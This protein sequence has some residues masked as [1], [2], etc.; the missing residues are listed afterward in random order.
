MLALRLE[1]ADEADLGD[2]LLDLVLEHAAVALGLDDPEAVEKDVPFRDQRL[3]S[4][5]GA[6]MCVALAKATGLALPVTAVFDYPTPIVLAEHLEQ[7]AR[8]DAAPESVPTVRATVHDDDPVA[9]VGLACRLPGGVSSPEQLWQLLIDDR[10]VV[11][12]FPA[13]RGWEMSQLA[14]S[15]TS[16]GGFL[17]DAADFDA[18]FFGI[19]PREAQAMDPQQR[20]VLETSWEAIERAGIDPRTLRGSDTGVF[21]GAMAQDYGLRLHEPSDGSDGYR[22]TG[23]TTSVASGRVAYALGL[24]GPA[25]TVDTACSSSL[26]AVHLAADAV[27]RGECGIALAGGVTV[28]SSPGIFVEFSRQGG[29]SPDGR[30]KAFSDDAD[31]TG[32]GE[33]VGLLLLERLSDAQR[34]GHPILAVIR[35]SAVNQDGASN[36]LTAPNGPSQQRVIR[37]ALA[38]AGLKPRDVD[39]VEAHGTGTRLGDP[40][41][42]QALLATYGQDRE[43]PLWLGSIKSNI[44][45][46]QAAAGAAGIIKMILAMHHGTLPRTLHI[47]QP[48]TEVDWN[49]GQLALLTEAQPWPRHDRPRRAAVSSFGISGTNAHVIL[50]QPPAADAPSRVPAP[51]LSDAPWLLS[52]VDERALQDQAGRLARYLH[53]AP[54]VSPDDVGYTLAMSRGGFTTRAA[55][56][57]HSVEERADALSALARGTVHPSV[58]RGAAAASGRVVFVFP[59]Q[60]SQWP[61]MGADLYDT[62]PVFADWIDR[63]EQALAPHVNWSLTDILR[64]D[65]TALD[66]VDV[67]QPAL[68]A[69]MVSL[70]ETWRSLGIHPDAVIGHSQGEIAAATLAGALTLDDAARIVALR[71]QIIAQRLAGQGSMASVALSATALNDHLTNHP[72]ITLA[73][74]NGPHTTVVAG[75]SEPLEHFLTHLEQQDIRV[76]RI[77]VD[78][79]SHT[80]E[81]ETIRTELATALADITPRTTH[82]DFYS[83]VTG[84]RTDGTE[85]T[86]DYWYQNLRQPVQFHPTVN[87]LLNDR[88]TTFLEP[89]AHPVLTASVQDTADV[90]DVEVTVN[91]ALRRHG[92]SRA[93]FFASTASVWVR[94]HH[95]D[96]AAQYPG[97]GLVPLPTYPFQRTRYWTDA[98]THSASSDARS[99]GDR[100]FWK[101]VGDRDADALASLLG[102][103]EEQ[104]GWLSQ[105]LPALSRRHDRHRQSSDLAALSYVV[106]W[107]PSSRTGSGAPTGKWLVIVPDG[108]HDTEWSQ[109]VRAGLGASGAE[110]VELRVGSEDRHTL[111]NRLPRDANAVVSLLPMVDSAARNDEAVPAGTAAT[112]TL[113]HALA[114]AGLDVPLWTLTSGAVA[115]DQTDALRNPEQSQVWG[116]GR[117]AALEQP[118]RWGGLVDLPSSPSERTV[119]SLLSV[120]AQGDEDQVAIRES[121]TFVRRLVHASA[122]RPA[123]EVRRDRGT[124]LITGGTGALGAQ[125]ARRIA[126]EGA[127]H[128]VLASR[129][130]P[131]APGAQSLAAELQAL[132]TRVD[133]VVCDVADRAAV[134]QL[135]EDFTVTSVFHAA[136]I[137]DD[138]VVDLLTVEQLDQVLRVKAVGAR[139]L[140]EL[141]ADLDEFVLFSSIAG[142]LGIPG[143]G[144]YAPGNAYLD[145][146]AEHR[147]SLGL[148]ATSYAWGPWAG[149]GMAALDGVQDRLQRHGVLPL[150]PDLAL[151]LLAQGAGEDGAS[152]MVADIQWDRFH[153]AY[154]EARSRPFIEDLPEVRAHAAAETR[155]KDREPSSAAVSR[156]R[157]L[158]GSARSAAVLEMVRAQVAAVLGHTDVLSLDVQRPLRDLGFDSLTGVDLRNRLAAETGIR[159]P[160]SLIFDYPTASAV[161]HHVEAMLFGESDVDTVAVSSQSSDDDPVVIVAMACRYPGSVGSPE[162]L[163]QLLVDG[164]DAIGDFPTDRGWDLERLL[165]SK[166]PGRSVTGRG[167]FLYDAADFDTGL[168]G[169]SPREAL[170]MDPQQRLL[171]EAAWETFE[172]AGIDPS[173]VRGSQ[174]GVFVG[175]TYQDYQS[176]VA[177]PPAE[178]EGYLLTG[179]TASVASGRIS[180]TFGLEGPAVTIDTACS[181]SLVALHLAVESV[182]RGESSAALAGGV[183]LMATP[184]MFTEF[185]RQQG[186]SSDGTCK[187]FSSDADGFGSAEG[188]GLLLVERLSEA[189]SKGHPVLA[190]VRGSA[191]NQDGASN[192]LTAPNGPSQQRVIRQALANA[193]LKPSDVDAVEAHGTG[194]RLGDPIEAQAL[195]AAYGQD[196]EQPLWLGSIKSNIGH[197]QA[198]AGAAGIIK[199]ILA[200][201]HGTLPRTLHITE[202]TTEVDWS[203]GQLALLTEE[204]SWPEHDRPRRAAVSSFG[205]SGTNAH[206]ILE[207]APALSETERAVPESG[208]IPWVMSA[209]NADGLREQ[210][211]RLSSLTGGTLADVGYSLVKARAALEHRAVVLGAT[212]EAMATGLAAVAQGSPAGNVVEGVASAGNGRVVFVFPGQGSQ[213]PGMGAD[214]YDTSPVFADWIDRC[215]QALAPHV[216]WSLTDVLRNDHTAL[217]RVDVVQPALWAMMVSLA[218]TWRSLGIHPDA[219]IGHSQGEIAAATLAGALTL[220]DAAR[221]VALRSQIIAQ[222]LAGQGSMASVALSATALHDHLTNH[223]HITLA[224]HNGPHT[225]VVAGPSEPLE[226]FLTH[227]EQ[228]DIRVRRITV[229]YASHTPEVETI[230][231]ELATALADITPRTTHIDFYSTV[232]GTRTDGTEL[233]PDYWY[234]N[235][236]QP[237]QFH[238]TVNKLLND[239][240]TTFLE[241]SA[242]PVLTAPLTE[243]SDGITVIGT[244][245]RDSGSLD[246]MLASAA[247]AWVSGLPVDWTG[248]YPGARHTP[249]PTYPFQRTRY[250]MED[251]GTGAADLSA[252]GQTALDHPLLTA[253]VDHPNGLETLFTGRVALDQQPWLSDHAVA[254]VLLLPGTAFLEMAVRAGDEV[255][256]DLVEDLTLSA[257][258]VVPEH[259]GTLLRVQV[260]SLDAGR[261]ALAV[262]ARA[263]NALQGDPWTLHASGTL[264]RSEPAAVPVPQA[265]LP[266]DASPVQVESTYR[267]LARHGYAYGPAFQGLRAL[268]QADGEVFAEIA[269]PV[270]QHVLA[271]RFVLHPALLDAAAQTV[272]FAANPQNGLTSVLPWEWQNFTVHSSGATAARAHLSQVS[273]TEARLLLLDPSGL[274]IAEAGAL[275]LRQVDLA[276]IA[277]LNGGDSVPL[278][279]DWREFTTASVVPADII[280]HV[281][282]QTAADLVALA[283][284]VDAEG[285]EPPSLVFARLDREYPA[286]EEPSAAAAHAAASQT[287]QLLQTWLAEPVFEQ[288]HL[289]FVTS[290]AA[291]V[292]PDDAV[293]TRSATVWGMVR[294]AQTEHPDRFVLADL[295]GSLKSDQVLPITVASGEPQIAIRGGKPLFP[296]LIRL[297]A[298]EPAAAGDD[299]DGTVL[300]T[301]GTGTVG[302]HIARHLVAHHG[303]RRLLLLS[304]KGMEADGAASL[305]ADLRDNGAH[306]EIVACDAADRAK[307]ATI[308]DEL[309][310]TYPVTAVIHAA[311]ALADGALMSLT[312][313]QVTQVLRP[314]IDAAVHL[315]ELARQHQVPRF[316]LVSSAAGVLGSAGQA[317]YAAA[318]AF[319]DA[320]A[321][322]RHGQGER[323]VSLAWGLWAD[324]SA[325]TSTLTETDVRRLSALGIAPM[326]T[327]AALASFDIAWRGNDEPV[328]VPMRVDATALSAM[329][330]PVPPMLRDLVRAPM[331]RAL[332]PSGKDD[333]PMADIPVEQRAEVLLNLVRTRA[334]A[335]LGYDSPERV[336]A[337]RAFRD[338]GFDSLAAVDLRNQLNVATGLRLPATV[339][340][341]HPTPASMSEHLLEA[342]YGQAQMTATV[343]PVASQTDDPVVIVAMSC[344]FPGG[345]SSP[346]A[347]WRLLSDA[348]DAVAAMPSDRGWFPDRMYGSDGAG[349]SAVNTAEGAFLP[350]AADFD[351]DLFG[352]SPREALAMDPQQRLLLETSWEAFERAGIDPRSLRGTAT[353]VFAGVMYHDYG[354][355]LTD[356]PAEVEGYVINGS[357]GSVASGRVAYA[358]GLEGPAI[359]IDTACSSSLVA[360]HLAANAI[361]NGECTMALAGGVTVMSTP[362]PFVE[363]SRQGGLASD[364]RCKAFSDTADGT[365]WGEGV[366]LLLLERLSDAQRNGHS[367][368]AVIRGSAVNQ[369]GASNGLTAPNGPSQQRVIRQALANA[370]LKPRDVDAVEAHGTGTRLG[371][372]IEAQALLATYGQDREQPL[373]LGSIKSN[374]GH[375]Q[376]AAGAAGIIKMILA[377]H[378]GTL[379]RTL[380]ITQPTSQVD[381]AAGHISLLTEEQPWPQH[382]RPRRAGV[383]S[384]GVS[385]TNAHIILEQPPRED[386]PADSVPGLPV[387]PWVLSA[388]D[389]YAL[390]A[391][392]SQLV[393]SL[394]DDA[395]LLDI[396]YTLSTTRASFDER[397]VVWAG[398]LEVQRQAL[399]ALSK[400]TAH[401]TCVSG[402]R[403]GG[404]L[405]LLFSGQG[406]QRLGM[407]RE[408]YDAYS[409][410]ADAFDTVCAELDPHLPRPLRDVIF[411]D[412]ADVLNETQFTQP[413]LFAVHVALYRLWESWGVT[414]DAVV[415]HSIG[416]IAAAYIA[417]VLDLADAATLIIAR[418][419]L[420]QDMP[421]GGAMV[422]IDIAE[423]DILP[424]LHDYVDSVGIAAVNSSRS[425]VLS[426]DRTALTHITDRLEGHRITWLRVSHAFHSPL[427]EPILDEFR[428]A[429][430]GLTF[431]AP[432]IPLISSVTGRSIDHVDA[433]HWIRHARHTVR[434]ADALAHAPA[435]AYLEIGPGATLLP[436]VTGTAIP[437]LDP[438]KAEVQAITSALAKLTVTGIDVDWVTYFAGSGARRIP[439]PT[440]PFQH[441]RYWLDN[442][443]SGAVDLSAAGLDSADHPILKASVTIPSSGRT[444]LTGRIDLSSLPWLADHTVGDNVVFPGTAF[445]DLVLYA[446]QRVNCSRL[447]E[448]TMDVP[449]LL[450]ASEPVQVRVDVDE[451]VSGRHTVGV[452]SRP[453]HADQSE[454]WTKHC[455]GSL[456]TATALPLEAAVQWPPADAV[457]IDI[458]DFYDRMAESGVTYGPAFR[459]MRSVWQHGEELYAEIRMDGNSAGFTVHPALFDAALHVMA[460][461]ADQAHVTLPFAWS[462]VTVHNRASDHLLIRLAHRGPDEVTLDLADAA[463]AHIAS[464]SS[465]VGR[466]IPEAELRPRPVPALRMD[467]QPLVLPTVSDMPAGVDILRITAQHSSSEDVAESAR[468]TAEAAMNSV[469]TW[470][471]Q[472]HSPGARLV[473]ATSG[474]S[475]HDPHQLLPAASVWGLVRSAQVEHPG[476]LVLV[477]GDGPLDAA[478]AS[479]EEQILLHSDQALVPRLIRDTSTANVSP[480]RPGTVLVTGASGALGSRICRH[481]VKAHGFRRLLLVTRRG[482][483][484]SGASELYRQLAQLGAEVDF[485]ACDITDRQ[486]LSEVLS[487][488]PADWPLSAVVH[489]AGVVDDATFEQQSSERLRSVF[490]PKAQGAWN[491]HE[492]TRELDVSAFVLFSSAAGTLG[493]AGQANYAAANAFLDALAESRREQGL[494]ALSLAWG[495]WNVADGMAG[496][497][498]SVDRKRLARSGV[499][500]MEEEQGLALFDIALGSEHA[501]VVPL[502]LDRNAL[503]SVPGPVPCVLRGSAAAPGAKRP[504]EFAASLNERVSSLSGDARRRL[505]VET[506]RAEVAA[507]LGHVSEA[508]VD[509]RRSFSDLGFDSLTAVEL[510]NRLSALT[511]L[512][513]PA[514]VVFDYPST[515]ALADYLDAELPGAV[516]ALS[517]ELDR[518]EDLLSAAGGETDHA[519]IAGRLEY[520][521]A[522]W[523]RLVPTRGDDAGADAAEATTPEELMD[524]IDR[525]L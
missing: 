361:R 397:A 233:T 95:V 268:W 328:L 163:W 262:Y 206:V 481:L 357:A 383:S 474:M 487:A 524:F 440:Y 515:G 238:P 355:R 62:S 109:A 196:R 374:I 458:G 252:A 51:G 400:G 444:L 514:S 333:R 234:Q 7:R 135:L 437:S 360:V 485:A 466:P 455:S 130:G 106:R 102:L 174:T 120:V 321:Q 80:P 320:L 186:L 137:L 296:R 50:E 494:P 520:L 369:D 486:A 424:H 190:V 282:V 476:R 57:G 483:S 389:E 215:E 201:H 290:N 473:V 16:R 89:S 101:A 213:W 52:A 260:S 93:D 512:E 27:R 38:N 248:L 430:T 347:L 509:D 471:A 499:L 393:E 114:D 195:Q 247:Q 510:R 259:G 513:L 118:E 453:E 239:R 108:G 501:T 168:F 329:G 237:V 352:I 449:L 46:T 411:G 336:Q 446:G 489:C 368:L 251:H 261:H 232:T 5:S 175:L 98:L 362:A 308:F 244:L 64:N 301:G 354:A 367:V 391:A 281:D 399:V 263:V 67:V 331:R 421:A 402:T 231:T 414:P 134:T 208:V 405:T 293:S 72:H 171:L 425:L 371:D 122:Q 392:A 413:A 456:E 445:L 439:L 377:M 169:I 314:K 280:E 323:A 266:P 395:S 142:V 415:G 37:Q 178:L 289:V 467:W 525:N 384:F 160:S 92:G 110:L 353:G 127:R 21:V 198:A 348:G 343:S 479:G 420:M 426:G 13:D 451:A 22:L 264:A 285:A 324:R 303:V 156:I 66:R 332:P 100:E 277:R 408:L 31:G 365:G 341:D 125:V 319:L 242:H 507:T 90:A 78:Y 249:L 228:Q 34:N 2:V 182:R 349:A 342:L 199:M 6:E 214:L 25:L 452:Y 105:A 338:L 97:G 406:S 24:E 200:M 287:L 191:V 390:R 235:L 56:L 165:A 334:A 70:A 317:A 74:H 272:L 151:T 253:R 432:V 159:L 269:L 82:I 152:T 229:D 20:L 438:R 422:A 18:S 388:R 23:A 176:R 284:D 33:G 419:R 161:A 121:A 519:H 401:P 8:G 291:Q 309:S 373:W 504:Q 177:E 112:L 469:Q 29:L 245:R 459:G 274:P 30:C 211:R 149:D 435:D 475:S 495:L 136:G 267:D 170:A 226:H 322:L 202:P 154:S 441:Q 448:L 14:G 265:W 522:E 222:R 358:F 193:G 54:E 442:V 378:H 454:S 518:L 326:P 310:E 257:P 416:E 417:G 86:P 298:S 158:S 123:A 386:V 76:R 227:L 144:G 69:M 192:G 187:A 428:R 103:E 412:D 403:S 502:L 12:A 427:M 71:S 115:V 220:D 423:E 256:C 85:L 246:R 356:V 181:S 312:R 111:G 44:G 94:G 335:V 139:H 318:N 258:L 460:L 73:A 212:G 53:A 490:G 173:S 148:P 330:G 3:T 150:D 302:G 270:D 143:Q 461:D 84:T 382:D 132:G 217:D 381:W 398:D 299:I 370:G 470:L 464:V 294:S 376:A 9:V 273:A 255:G 477:D 311:G 79:A 292:L 418:S 286:E 19:S 305:L 493:S 48:T 279:V 379:P 492:L 465:L 429:V 506:V 153:L 35:G 241:P 447:V 306:A 42:A 157:A 147:R 129:R 61:G 523:N 396:G 468:K 17:Y 407:G 167:G 288:S 230:R 363:F 327:D 462:G 131:Q 203:E 141:T 49:T 387:V 488:I 497:L 145:A 254:G 164:G 99:G 45:H 380:H 431:S 517:E 162:D 26:V 172:R 394:T 11:G 126:R 60:G 339:V 508:H 65:H 113:I 375:T 216:D 434:F 316:I 409:V 275:L 385:G 436:H 209:N 243:S 204:R 1:Q 482:E 55:V 511:G 138:A 315:H 325:L 359:T 140:H 463:G 47:T 117:V 224:A 218:E 207:Q 283:T 346:E 194:T 351:A 146:L 59:G 240:Y 87:K 364:G 410:Y 107:T 278:R 498:G 478:V 15:A 43:Q 480:W 39:A 179:V 10:D 516:D 63:C 180:Y 116:L 450:V 372:P 91:G 183:A 344:R 219:V 166:G 119:E 366:G 271:E 457:P 472:H 28:M 503:R 68:W 124:V 295:D 340:F 96:W 337:D 36:G 500:P 223:P 433:E 128:V 304:R 77:T 197:T 104:S 443:P 81:V 496:E 184:H 88:Y 404:R 58:V 297:T 307:L 4:V 345:S 205:V 40:I 505:L 484:A 276:D 350:D 221:I 491:L 32:W 155:S 313:D 250:W 75:P 210:A 133:V 189:R 185:S 300:I 188:V 236:R 83:T 225:T 521:L 41:E